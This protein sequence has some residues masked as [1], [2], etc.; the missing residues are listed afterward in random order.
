MV[1]KGNQRKS[2]QFGG[3]PKQKTHHATVSPCAS[4]DSTR[5]DP[6]GLLRTTSFAE[7]RLRVGHVAC[8][9]RRSQR[10][11][12]RPRN[13]TSPMHCVNKC[14]LFLRFETS[15][16]VSFG[17]T[18]PKTGNYAKQKE[19]AK[20]PGI[21][22]FATWADVSKR[23]RTCKVKGAQ[24]GFGVDPDQHSLR[25]NNQHARTCQMGC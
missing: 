5:G 7:R 18:N 8:E 10:V 6:R 4:H 11:A 22:R 21:T 16:Y 9:V 20:R 14:T 12:L 1:H 23:A 24:V 15:V 13:A 2:C 17:H 25:R 19:C 3:S